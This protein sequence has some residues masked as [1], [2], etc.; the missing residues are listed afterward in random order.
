MDPLL[1]GLGSAAIE[2]VLLNSSHFASIV[3]F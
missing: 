2:R 3:V 1:D